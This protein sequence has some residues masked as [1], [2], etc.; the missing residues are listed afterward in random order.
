MARLAKTLRQSLMPVLPKTA[1]Q[2]AWRRK[3]LL[4]RWSVLHRPRAR[5][6]SRS[7]PP[8]AGQWDSGRQHGVGIAVTAKGTFP[9]ERRSE[10][11]EPL[12]FGLRSFPEVAVGARQFR[13]LARGAFS[14]QGQE[15]HKG[16]AQEPPEVTGETTKT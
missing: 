8:L 16:L 15:L 9:K 10:P 2:E 1:R 7:A 4:A 13:V 3:T 12:V 11:V 6:V 14:L 5:L